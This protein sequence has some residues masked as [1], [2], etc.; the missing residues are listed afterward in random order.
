MKDDSQIQ[1]LNN[2]VPFPKK[3]KEQPGA[4]EIKIQAIL[5]ELERRGVS[6]TEMCITLIELVQDDLPELFFAAEDQM[7]AVKNNLDIILYVL[8]N[9]L[10]LKNIKLN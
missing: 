2:V 5:K 8:K 6:E 3:K 7:T 10:H 9:G 4:K 1:N